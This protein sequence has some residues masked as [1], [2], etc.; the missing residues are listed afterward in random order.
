MPVDTA[1]SIVTPADYIWT[2]KD[3]A[4]TRA[5]VEQALAEAVAF[6]EEHCDRIFRHG[7]H[8]ETLPSGSTGRVYPRARPVESVSAPSG[9]TLSGPAIATGR[10]GL[11]ALVVGWSGDPADVTVTYVGGYTHDTLPL[12]LRRAICRIAYLILHPG[13]AYADLPVNAKSVSV[14]DVSISGDGLSPLD[15]L[16]S[17]TLRD[18][19]RY[20][21][22]PLT[23]GPARR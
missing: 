21:R 18:L 14:G 7:T 11:N 17:A 2:T 4:T 22:Q 23:A 13:T 19:A 12:K 16:D 15:L 6:A 3:T 9:A 10:G 1:Q 5:E 20:T 8:T